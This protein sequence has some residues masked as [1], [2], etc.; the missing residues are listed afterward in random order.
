[1][2]QRGV[3]NRL[4]GRTRQLDRHC[5]RKN[6]R[7]FVRTE[8]PA[9]QCEVV[10]VRYRGERHLHRWTVAATAAQTLRISSYRFFTATAVHKKPDVHR[11]QCDTKRKKRPNTVASGKSG[12]EISLPKEYTSLPEIPGG[13]KAPPD[14]DWFWNYE[15]LHIFFVGKVRSP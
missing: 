9:P 6:I 5:G 15:F 11:Q 1:M 10:L 7:P 3:P 13:D 8:P 4:Q 2:R 14:I 12:Y